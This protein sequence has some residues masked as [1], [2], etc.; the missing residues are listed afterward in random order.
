M[1]LALLQ[2]LGPQEHPHESHTSSLSFLSHR[3][4]LPP[5]P[6]GHGWA[7]DLSTEGDQVLGQV[8]ADH[9]LTSFVQKLMPVPRRRSRGR[10]RSRTDSPPAH[11]SSTPASS[12]SAGERGV[13]TRTQGAARGR[14]RET[15][16][17]LH[18][19]ELYA[20]SLSMSLASELSASEAA[21]PL[22]RSRWELV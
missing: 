16:W 4:F 13:S 14:C 21:G 9:P 1:C 15:P 5:A 3:H 17:R 19:R 20:P 6:W 11:G 2:A 10:L 18:F 12:L 7:S 8:P 22:V